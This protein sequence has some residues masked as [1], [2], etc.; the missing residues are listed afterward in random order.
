[1]SK[2]LQADFH[3]VALSVKNFDEIKNF[4]INILGYDVLWD[5]D[6][7][8][9]EALSNV[10]GLADA[11]MHIAMLQGYGMRIE[12]F[13]YYEPQGKPRTPARQCDF[14]QTHFALS[15]KGLKNMHSRLQTKGVTFVSPPQNIRPGAWV[16]YMRD[17]EGNTIELVEYE[18]EAS[19]TSV[20]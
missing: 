18:S 12:I 1:M 5:S 7:R 8:G 3:H 15:V 4:Y 10:V 6:N 19:A 13:H 20:R 16:A 2:K 14:G 11:R 17:P 9:N